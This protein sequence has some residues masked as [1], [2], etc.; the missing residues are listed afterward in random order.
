MD[1]CYWIVKSQWDP[2]DS[3]K[4]V[5][6]LRQN[7]PGRSNKIPDESDDPDVALRTAQ[8]SKTWLHAGFSMAEDWMSWWSYIEATFRDNGSMKL[9]VILK[10]LL[11]TIP[12]P[13]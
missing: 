2:M 12:L 10:T 7:Q 9:P 11:S 5:S 8:I 13:E 3:G 4:L 6:R 1:V